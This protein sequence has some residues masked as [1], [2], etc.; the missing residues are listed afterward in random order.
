MTEDLHPHPPQKLSPPP[1]FFSL[2]FLLSLSEGQRR[3]QPGVISAGN[4]LLKD[5]SN[6][7]RGMALGRGGS[8]NIQ[9]PAG[10]QPPLSPHPT[11]PTIHFLLLVACSRNP[12][13]PQEPRSH[14]KACVCEVLSGVWPLAA[15]KEIVYIL[16]VKCLLDEPLEW[17]I[18]QV[19]SDSQRGPGPQRI[20]IFD[21]VKFSGFS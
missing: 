7:Q 16:S 21:L 19:L 11:P 5:P 14:Q 10:T 9:R 20:I 3:A 12:M 2:P 6:H 15:Q 18:S 4:S 17:P 8:S 13:L 1:P